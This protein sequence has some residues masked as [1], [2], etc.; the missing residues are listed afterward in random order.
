MPDNDHQAR[1]TRFSKDGTTAFVR[2][3]VTRRAYEYARHWA[4]FHR[5]AMPDGTAEDQL[6]GDLNMAIINWQCPPEIEALYL[7]PRPAPPSAPR[8]AGDLDDDIPF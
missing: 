8:S 6:E 1:S 3:R 4:R 7:P 2:L 5:G